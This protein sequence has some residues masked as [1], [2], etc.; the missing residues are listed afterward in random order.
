MKIVVCDDD[1]TLRGVV[2]KLATDAG[3]SVLAE[4]DSAADA[5]DMI[6][7]FG[8]E[9][10]ILDLA[11]PWGGGLRVVHELREAGSPCQ[12]VVFTSYAAD[13]PDV[14]DAGVR[15]VIEKP[16]FEGLVDV[17]DELAK[18]QKATT[19]AGAERRR[20]F[21]PRS[22]M[23]PAG[24]PSASGV[25]SP[26]TFA[27]AL[28]H[29]EPGDAVL[30]VHVATPDAG[31]GWY[32]RLAAADHTLAVARN[33]RSVLRTQDRLTVGEP[34][35]EERIADLRAL[36]LGGGRPGVESVFRRLERAHVTLGLP[37]VLNGGWAVVEEGV[38]GSL[39]VARADDAARR[40]VGKPEGD[41]L[42]AG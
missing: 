8:A 39:V 7:R 11:L 26:H 4:T 10:L 28:N 24:A 16:D 19:P 27:D 2:S 21:V 14:R 12:I 5:V 32:A 34:D 37:G 30:V 9:A 17:L 13:S 31:A 22:S 23:P 42:W 18:G 40:G 20:A 15:A 35:T 6:L 29:L 36:L 25:E 1:V 41:R 33:L 3:H 38:T